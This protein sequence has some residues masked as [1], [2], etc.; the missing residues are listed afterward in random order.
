MFLIKGFDACGRKIWLNSNNCWVGSKDNAKVFRE[1]E[2]ND[3]VK[4]IK[5]R[6][7]YA[8]SQD[9]VEPSIVRMK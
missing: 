7:L 2:A 5:R 8:D 4:E 3:Q 6:N 9:R 1:S